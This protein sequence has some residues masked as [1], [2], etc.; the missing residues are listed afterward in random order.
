[1]VKED[2]G[3]STSVDETVRHKRNRPAN[4]NYNKIPN[5]LRINVIYSK[6]I[7]DMSF[8]EISAEL[9]VNYNSVRNIL[10]VHKDTKLLKR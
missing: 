6:E 4:L 7:L 3:S 10:K 9:G 8:R 1:M 2:F 5:V